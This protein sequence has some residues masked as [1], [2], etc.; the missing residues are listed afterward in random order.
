MWVWDNYQNSAWPFVLMV[1][2]IVVAIVYVAS[3]YAIE[4]LGLK[5]LQKKWFTYGYFGSLFT[6]FLLFLGSS[7]DPLR[8]VLGALSLIVVPFL[9]IAEGVSSLLPLQRI[10]GW[11]GNDAQFFFVFGTCVVSFPMAYG[12]LVSL[13]A[14]IVNRMKRRKA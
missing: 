12:V 10:L 3:L 13:I 8:M 1:A 9:F 7:I 2:V 11:H 6:V 5:W 14:S 4:G